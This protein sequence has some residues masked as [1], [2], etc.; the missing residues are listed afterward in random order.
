[1][2]DW[3]VEARR[4]LRVEIARRDKTYRQL[5][6]RLANMGLA[7]TES[8]VRNKLSRGSFSFAFGLQCLHALGVTALDVSVR[9]APSPEPKPKPS[10]KAQPGDSKPGSQTTGKSAKAVTR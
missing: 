2:T 6:E 4:V 8:S 9:G 1:M 10:D 3:N 7:E 5:A